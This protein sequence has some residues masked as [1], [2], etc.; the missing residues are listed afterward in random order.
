MS[1]QHWNAKIIDPALVRPRIDHTL[2][3]KSVSLELIPVILV[4]LMTNLS[5]PLSRASNYSRILYNQIHQIKLA[6]F[7]ALFD[8]MYY[9]G[10]PAMIY[11]LALAPASFRNYCYWFS[12]FI[13]HIIILHYSDKYKTLGDIDE[14]VLSAYVYSECRRGMNPT[15]IRGVLSAIRHILFPHAK[16]FSWLFKSSLWFKKLFQFIDKIYGR[17]RKKKLP[18]T[19]HLLSKIVVII[20][21]DQLK[22]VRDWLIMILTHSAGFRGVEVRVLLWTDIIVSPYEDTITGRQMVIL[23]FHLDSTKT[24]KQGN[25][26]TVSISTPLHNTVFNIAT[27]LLR[28]IKLLKQNKITSRYVFPSLKKSDRGLKPISTATIRKNNQARYHEATGRPGTEVGAHS[29]RSGFV[30]DAVAA[31][32]PTELIKRTGRWKSDCWRVYYHDEQHA[33]VQAT[34]EMNSFQD[35]FKFPKKYDFDL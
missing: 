8:P 32:I 3:V 10:L 27:I 22:D 19:F 2:K 17:P 34:T 28:Y 7:M 26:A 15:T 23:I 29:G 9:D 30:T 13:F 31:G 33:Q 24:D 1:Q 6:D 25:G 16:H 35:N 18:L 14:Q 21:F 20:K 12:R 5:L 4:Q 11:T